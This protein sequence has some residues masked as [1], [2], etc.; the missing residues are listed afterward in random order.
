VFLYKQK[1]KNFSF[2]FLRT[3]TLVSNET[4]PGVFRGKHLHQFIIQIWAFTCEKPN[5][6]LRFFLIRFLGLGN[7]YYHKIDIRL[8]L[9]IFRNFYMRNKIR[10]WGRS[11]NLMRARTICA[12]AVIWTG[13]LPTTRQNCYHFEKFVRYGDM[14]HYSL[15]VQPVSVSNTQPWLR[16]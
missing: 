8:C 10:K 12:H 11:R 6:L 1:H 13:N 3:N 16:Q 14:V 15:F 5:F 2:S 4:L 9:I 7:H